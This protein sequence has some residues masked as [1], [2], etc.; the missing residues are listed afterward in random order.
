MDKL[1]KGWEID[2]LMNFCSRIT[3]GSHHSPKSV[4]VGLPYVTVKDVDNDG[5]IDLINCKKIS[6]TDF[7]ILVKGNCQPNIGDVLLSKD[8]TV[9]KTAIV[10]RNDFVLLSSLAILSPNQDLDSK[11]LFYFLNS[12][13][14]QDTAVRAK[15]GAA[16]KRIVLRTIKE[17]KI[18]LPPLPEQ[19]RIVSKL[20][21]LFERIDK[22]MALLEENITHTESL[23][24]SALDEVFTSVPAEKYSPILDVCSIANKNIV[25]NGNEVYNYVGLE[26]IESETGRLVEFSKTNGSEIK[27]SKV[28][29]R[30][31]AVLY[32]KLRPYL[33]KVY[34]ADFDGVCTTEILPFYPNCDILTK[35]Y[36]AFY[37]RS[38]KFVNE[39]NNNTSGAR[40]PRATTTFFKKI[41]KVPVPTIEVQKKDVEKLKE[42]STKIFLLQ[43]EQQDKLNSLKA[44]KE[45]ILD[46]AFK[47]E[48]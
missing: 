37:L 23:M 36:L 17:F 9:G 5:N 3:D 31:G 29:F 34:I 11:Y 7:Q 30:K 27:S 19:K 46:K 20:D 8:G 2:R 1:P 41:A 24:A 47:G 15:T 18:P 26:N 28:V 39:V 45:S 16:I 43:E 4:E 25:P 10:K 13:N 22:S 33:N 48:I 21:A 12:P 40:M 6:E 44:L 35:E 14:F 42:L 38:K 32:G